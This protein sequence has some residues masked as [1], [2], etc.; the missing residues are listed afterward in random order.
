MPGEPEEAKIHTS[1]A[2]KK[3]VTRTN[4]LKNVRYAIKTLKGRLGDDGGSLYD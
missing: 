3:A 4:Q 1:D 2:S